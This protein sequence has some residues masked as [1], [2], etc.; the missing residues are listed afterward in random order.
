[1]GVVHRVIDHHLGREVAFK[2]PHQEMVGDPAAVR[3]FLKE[4]QITA[5]LQHPGIPPVFDIGMLVGGSPFMITKLIRGTTLEAVLKER[6]G[7]TDER[8]RLLRVFER[9][10]LTV[11]YANCRGV[12]HR[13]LEPAN[14][15]IDAFGEVQVL[16]WGL[17]LVIGEM[18]GT[19]A[20]EDA[21]CGAHFGNAAYLAPEQAR[22]ETSDT[23][24]D[25][26]GLGGLLCHIL[27][28]EPPF[29]GESLAVVARKAATAE[30]GDAASRLERCK[31]E[32]ELVALARQCL[33]PQREDR[34]P[35]AQEVARRVAMT[36]RA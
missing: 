23:R 33:R 19:V 5:Q 34:P 32:K 4:V 15:M 12:V 14:V 21:R 1:M 13:D 10:C 17:A 9:V 20:V 25:V 26:F 31:G 22:G 2:V 30:L 27:T 36:R 16:D 28:G 29:R 24:A 35:D 8:P 7:P 11:A 6:S 18:T 3:R